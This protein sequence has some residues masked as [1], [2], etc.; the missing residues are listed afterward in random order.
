MRRAAA[1]L[2]LALF[3]GSAVAQ[4]P[5]PGTG[6]QAMIAQFRAGPPHR[7]PAVG[8]GMLDDG[9]SL[10]I[11]GMGHG[12]VSF[13]GVDG[14]TYL[15]IEMGEDTKV[16]LLTDALPV[17]LET[18]LGRAI[19]APARRLAGQT[20][21]IIPAAGETIEGVAGQGFD[22]VLVEGRRR[23]PG[24]RVVISADPRLAATGREILRVYDE[25]RGPL[26]AIA[27]REPQP[28]V[29]FRTLLARGVPI[30]IGGFRLEGI[31]RG[32]IHADRLTFPTPLA[33][34]AFRQAVRDYIGPPSVEHDGAG[35]EMPHADNSL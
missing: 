19:S 23:G 12:G 15:Q 14:R 5:A 16:G 28:Y 34:E 8:I 24:L 17:L 35:N 26:L 33:G 6:R 11:V 27:G 32:E 22:L 13:L 1:A 3:V 4:P 25:M 30:R 10:I 21:E 9:R 18:G 31:E 29:A 20:L 2:A 7:E